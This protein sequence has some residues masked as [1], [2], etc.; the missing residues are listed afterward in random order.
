VLAG[1][2][3]AAGGDHGLGFPAYERAMAETVRQS[4]QIGP[5]VLRTLVPRSRAQVR[6]IPHVLRLLSR[7][8]PPLQRALTS[9]GGG[10]AKMLDAVVLKDVV[11]V[12]PGP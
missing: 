6:A 12:P 4:R 2:L 11:R 10:P 8:P 5:A 3:A 9:Y 7:L 1:E